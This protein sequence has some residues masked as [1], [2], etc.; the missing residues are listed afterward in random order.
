MSELV[1][2]KNTG[3]TPTPMHTQSFEA[4]VDIAPG[5]SSAS[6]KRNRDETLAFG[7]QGVH[8]CRGYAPTPMDIGVTCQG[9]AGFTPTLTFG[10]SG[11]THKHMKQ[12]TDYT[13]FSQPT[14]SRRRSFGSTDRKL[15]WGFTLIEI[16]LVIA[17]IAILA[18]IV[19]VAINPSKQLG[20]AQD[21]QRASDVK[22]ILD[23][24]G[25]YSIDNDGALPSGIPI[26]TTC[27]ADG[28]PICTADSGCTGVNLDI[29]VSQR[30]YLTDLPAD[31]TGATTLVTGYYIFKNSY[32]RVG[33]C[34]PSTY[35]DDV[36]SIMR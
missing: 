25:Q 2:Q 31:P 14:Y 35:A 16:L 30:K 26:G 1:T 19:I 18:A 5:I 34:A 8:W 22:A 7:Q 4:I 20:A 10:Q 3:F 29:L 36:I 32:G 21:A 11:G 27:E 23:A 33:V 6:Q 9:Q 15:V 28:D 24:V 17:I 12:L 13:P